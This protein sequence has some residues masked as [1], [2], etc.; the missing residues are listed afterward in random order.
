MGSGRIW[1][2]KILTFPL[3]KQHVSAHL[4]AQGLVEPHLGCGWD[5]EAGTGAQ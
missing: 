4:T 1:E 3:G 2:H 5:A